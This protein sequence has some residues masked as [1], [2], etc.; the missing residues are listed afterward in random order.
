MAWNHLLEPETSSSKTPV[1]AGEKHLALD[2]AFLEAAE[3]GLIGES[4]RLW[5]SSCPFVVLGAGG[6]IAEEADLA[7]CENHNIPLLRRCSGGGTVLQGPCCL[8]YALVLSLEYRPSCAS[9]DGTT[10]LVLGRITQMLARQNVLAEWRG[11]SDLAVADFKISG[12]AQRRKKR[13]VLFHGTLLLSG[14]DFE[15]MARGLKHPPRQPGWR[16]QRHHNEFVRPI[17]L[18]RKQ[19]WTDALEIW[20]GQP[21]QEIPLEIR[22]LAQA[23]IAEKYGRREWNRS[24]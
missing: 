18:D 22:N 12:N 4:L 1:F 16:N 13:H 6:R 3:A 17:M 5:E 10:Q 8:N 9:I 2:E 21:K 20:H 11:T 14:F 15:T 23:L 7:W 19:L 24:M